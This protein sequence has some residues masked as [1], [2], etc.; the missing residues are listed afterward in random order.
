M[1]NEIKNLLM[2]IDNINWVQYETAYSE[3]GEKI[4]GYLKDLFCGD[5][6]TKMKAI[7]MLWCSLCHQH[8][9][10][11]LAALPSYNFLLY[12]LL[13]LD[14][15]FKVEL[16]DIFTGFAVCTIYQNSKWIYQLRETLKNDLKIF[17]SFI[18]HSNEDISYFSKR[19]CEY[20][21]N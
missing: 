11:S 3:T 20:L 7:H 4:A 8:A 1:D 6:S 10:V 2:E 5:K 21:E 13:N 14:D 9:Y 12:A 16:L 18:F 15:D 17:K 19:I